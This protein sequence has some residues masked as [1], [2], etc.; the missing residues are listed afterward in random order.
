MVVTRRDANLQPT[1]G[2]VVSEDLDR[3]RLRE[4][5]SSYDDVCIFY[6]GASQYPLL[7]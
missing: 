1:A 4:H 5:L 7:L 6:A 2:R 3:Y